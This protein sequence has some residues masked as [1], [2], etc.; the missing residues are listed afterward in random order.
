MVLQ[1]IVL[2]EV[3]RAFPE[4]QRSLAC[5]K[6]PC[7]ILLF[8]LTGTFVC[9]QFLIQCKKSQQEE[10]AS[11]LPEWSSTTLES[12]VFLT[13]GRPFSTSSYSS[14]CVCVCVRACM[15]DVCVHVRA[16][17]VWCVCVVWH[18]HTHTQ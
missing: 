6:K 14:V 18:V 8:L 13:L 3:A 5:V 15:C 9:Y 2:Q 12:S 10:D 11:I 7:A 17:D 16:C 1:Y 4:D